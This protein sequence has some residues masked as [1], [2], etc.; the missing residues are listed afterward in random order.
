M[1]KQGVKPKIEAPF[2][3]H[4]LIKI[5]IGALA[6]LIS[7]LILE[8][9][10]TPWEELP[11]AF[12][13]GAVPGFVERQPRKAL[14]GALAAAAGWLGG[15]LIFGI[16]IELGI[17]A[18]IGAGSFLG[19]FAGTGG[20]LSWRAPAGFALG[21]FAGLL[22]ELSRYLTVVV[23]PFRTWDMQFILLVSAGLLLNA[24]AAAITPA[25]KKVSRA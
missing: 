9:L 19:C 15:A 23:E 2:K 10:K 6:G 21:A 1:A 25:R 5:L 11:A 7:Y 20:R 17:G 12:L 24:A 8:Q 18:W 14:I 13:I 3:R 4:L 22:A 16:G